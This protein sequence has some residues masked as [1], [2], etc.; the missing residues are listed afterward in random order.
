MGRKRVKW[1]KS[2][3]RVN[4]RLYD[5]FYPAPERRKVQFSK[6][7]CVMG[8][9]LV[10]LAWLGNGILLWFGREPMSDVTVAI[11]TMFGG[12]AT[13][14]YF[15]LSGYRDGSLNKLRAKICESGRDF[16]FGEE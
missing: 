10:V 4:G 3:V 12:F 13:G 15:G 16:E 1:V 14:G 9:G 8:F 2:R 7:I 6:K 5:G 11:I